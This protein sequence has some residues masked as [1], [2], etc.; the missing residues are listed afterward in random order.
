M[1]YLFIVQILM[2]IQKLSLNLPIQV[3][4]LEIIIKLIDFHGFI[5]LIYVTHYKYYNIINLLDNLG[6]I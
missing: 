3:S 1:I 5:N 4:F 2:L 6:L